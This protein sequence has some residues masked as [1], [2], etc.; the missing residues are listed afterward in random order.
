ME[1]NIIEEKMNVAKLTRNFIRANQRILHHNRFFHE[2]ELN[3]MIKVKIDIEDPT[4]ITISEGKSMQKNDISN[5]A[6]DF[7]KSTE[8]AKFELKNGQT[9]TTK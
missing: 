3:G 9:T 4:Y 7:I 6:R 2:I 8:L 5:F 1:T